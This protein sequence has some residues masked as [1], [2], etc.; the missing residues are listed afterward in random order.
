M[1]GKKFDSLAA[2][3]GDIDE[4]YRGATFGNRYDGKYRVASVGSGTVESIIERL[5]M[6]FGVRFT[7]QAGGTVESIIERLMKRL[8]E[9]KKTQLVYLI[10]EENDG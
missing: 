3:V 4:K 5:M 7:E 1:S 6:F 9:R 2:L 8:K 10:L